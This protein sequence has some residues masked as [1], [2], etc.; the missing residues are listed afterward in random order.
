MWEPH[1]PIP[2]EA[3]FDEFVRLQGGKKLSD[4]LPPNPQFQNADYL[5][6]TEGIVAELKE[7]TTEFHKSNKHTAE[8]YEVYCELEKDG[9]ICW[10]D[11]IAGNFPQEF[12][13]RQLRLFRPPIQRILKKANRQIKDTKKALQR[14]NDLGLLFI[15][16]D[17][18]TAISPFSV[19]ALIADT[20][21]HSYKSIDGFVYLTVNSCVS[22]PS[23]EY[24]VLLWSA[25]YADGVPDRM[26]EFVDNL[27]RARRKFLDGKI[28]PFD[29]SYET[30]NHDILIGSEV[31]RW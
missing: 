14:E 30:P 11:V 24:A 9:L 10:D 13:F 3:T 4:F 23:S 25:S 28:G 17:S 16:N 26:V 19:K 6:E 5:F 15:V 12:R 27:G 31:I 8:L 18:F 21:V 20:L 7:I 22:L 1:K 29:I 2:V